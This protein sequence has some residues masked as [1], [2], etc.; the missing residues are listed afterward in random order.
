MRK[1]CRSALVPYS[2]REMF[3]LVDDIQ[4]YPEFLPWCNDAE[5]HSRSNGVVEATL[6]LHKGSV[7]KHFTTR[8]RLAQ[9]ESISIELLGGPF[10]HLSGGW[11][12][13]SLNEQGCKVTLD[14][15]FEFSSLIVDMM[16]GAY[17]EDTCSSLVEAFT[18]RAAEVFGKRS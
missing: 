8:N 7:S 9:F 4:A 12:F 1:V 6:E 13:K 10:R 14:L 5:V 11:Q 16:F 17:F 15:E 3:V 18:Q 2:A